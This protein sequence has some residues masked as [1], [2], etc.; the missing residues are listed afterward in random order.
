MHPQRKLAQVS[1]PKS[2]AFHPNARIFAFLLRAARTFTKKILLKTRARFATEVAHHRRRRYCRRGANSRKILRRNRTLFVAL[3][4]RTRAFLHLFCARRAHVR[5]KNYK[6][7]AQV[8]VQ[9]CCVISGDEAA[10]AT[11]TRAI[12]CTEI[13]RF[14]AARAHFLHL[15]CARRARVRRQICRKDARVSA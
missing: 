4:S 1:A 7:N 9:T 15:F 2:H 13:A 5:R 12:F 11:Q 14:P 10:H 8:S 6:N 3:A